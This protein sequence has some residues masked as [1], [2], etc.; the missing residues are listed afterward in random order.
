MRRPLANERWRRTVIF[1]ALMSC[2]GAAHAQSA[3]SLVLAFPPGGP[4]DS[5]ARVTARQ[6]EKELGQPV[7]IE[8][9][10]GGNGAIAANLV[11]R[12]KPDGNTLFLSSIGAIAINPSL[13]PK[14]VYNPEKDFVPVAM[15]ASSPEVLVVGHGHAINTASEYIRQAKSSGVKMASTGVGGMSHMGIVQFKLATSAKVLHVP[16]KGAPPA[17]TDTIGGQVDGFIGDISGLLANIKAGKLKALAIAAPK[18]S[19]VLPDVPTFD[20]I[21][22]PNVYVNNWYGLFAPT[23]TPAEKINAINAAV[24][25]AFTSSE[26]RAYAEST[27]VEFIA[28]TPQ[29][30]AETVKRDTAHWSALIRSEGI[31]VDE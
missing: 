24:Q 16:Y 5:L 3:V 11:A 28:G 26:M 14:L 22:V 15:L 19:R 29:Q 4:A 6:L 7:I 17:T 18:R 23:G 27:G 8:N 13:Y 21:G 10:P 9:K 25:R 20:E 1:L 31:K 12:S 2:A 30:F